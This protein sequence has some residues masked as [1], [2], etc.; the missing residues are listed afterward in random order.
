MANTLGRLFLV[1]VDAAAAPTV[2]AG[3]KVGQVFDGDFPQEPQKADKT[4]N[5]SGPREEHAVNRVTGDLTFKFYTN[6]SDP[7][8]DRLRAA[9]DVDS[10][11][12]GTGMVFVELHPEGTGSTKPKESFF[13]SVSLKR[14]LPKDGHSVTDCT[15]AVSGTIIRG[16]QA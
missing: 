11:G 15:L 4:S 13:A 6:R 10:P 16:T 5:D 14:G 2:G 12:T 8:Q 7:G 1:Y 9:L 3:S